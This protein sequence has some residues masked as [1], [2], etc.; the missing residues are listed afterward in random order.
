M[1]TEK[2]CFKLRLVSENDKEPIY[3]R[4]KSVS[5]ESLFDEDI[6]RHKKKVHIGREDNI[7]KFDTF[8]MIFPKKTSTL[9][10][11]FAWTLKSILNLL[12]TSFPLKL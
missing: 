6:N 10:L 8:H 7:S 4:I 2:T 11:H 5:K 12:S 3:F 9:N 1:I